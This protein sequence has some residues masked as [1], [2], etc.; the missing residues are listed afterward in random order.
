MKPNLR[1]LRPEEIEA[2]LR[3]ERP[4]AAPGILPAQLFGGL[5]RER[6]P[7]VAA[8]PEIGGR[9]RD[10]VAELFSDRGLELVE[11]RPAPDRSVR[12]VFRLHDGHLVESVLLWHHDLW[13]VCVSSQA[14][15]PLACS[16]CA[17]GMLGLRR[18][19]EPWEIVDQVVQVG[20]LADVRI[21]D[22]VFM[23]MGEPLLNEASVFAAAE[24]LNHPL[25]PQIGRKRITISTSGIV[26]AI[27]R[28]IDE[29]RRWR[30]VFSLSSAVPEKRARLMPVQKRWDFASFLDAVRRYE[31][32]RRHKHVT[33]EYIAIRNLTMGDDDIDAIREH[34]T[35]FNCI[36]NVIPL[37]P[38][39]NDE[40]EAPTMA[41]V[42]AWTARLRPLGIPV[43]IRYSG[44]QD[45]RAGCGQLGRALMEEGRLAPRLRV[46][47]APPSGPAGR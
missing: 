14:G 18:D 41:E 11:R 31:A 43:K 8:I 28:F 32:H 19:L 5:L 1:G 46:V 37:N 7:E 2:I 17:T 15:C 45:E 42:R 6:H 38:V 39:G 22:V 29:G 12:H 26:P 25:G 23:G 16:F 40:L 4:G 9:R 21:N 27:H 36:L 30:L 3:R 20:R 24:I 34:L 10:L 13:T 33:L 35:D 47:G 44:G